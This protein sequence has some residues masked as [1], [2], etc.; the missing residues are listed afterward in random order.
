VDLVKID[1]IHLEAAQAAFHLPPY[2]FR[3]QGMADLSPLVPDALAFCEDEK[4]AR[5]ALQCA[6]YFL[7]MAQAIHRGGL[8]PVQAGIQRGVYGRQGLVVVLRSPPESP[9][10]ASY[11]SA[12]DAHRRDLHVAASQPLRLYS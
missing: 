10:S 7:G 8:D 11:R 2:G 3:L 12:A 1:Y 6:A 4:P 5:T 9:A